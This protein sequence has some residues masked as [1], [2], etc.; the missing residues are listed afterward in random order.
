M[1]LYEYQGKE[2]FKR[3]GIPV[4]EGRLATTPAEAR[5]AAEELGGEVVVKAQ[6]L[7]GGRGKA[8]G[9]KLASDPDD[10]ERKA[11]EIL[12]LD[13][14]G[15]VVRRIWIERASEIASER[16]LSVTLDRGEKKPLLMFTTEGGVEIEQV[17]AETPDALVRLHVDPLA[18]YDDS[19]GRTLVGDD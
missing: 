8:G 10:A 1:D 4:S 2:L 13:I 19:I 6:V 9:I 7:T 14:R 5:R 11:A 15:H 17:A 16:Y 3:H 12:G 18:D